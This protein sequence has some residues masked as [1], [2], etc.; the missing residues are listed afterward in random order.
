MARLLPDAADVN[1]KGFDMDDRDSEEFMGRVGA[2]KPLI[3]ALFIAAIAALI[4]IG[5]RFVA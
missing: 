4:Y 5:V 1:R 2:M 3:V